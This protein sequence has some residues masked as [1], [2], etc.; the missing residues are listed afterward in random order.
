MVFSSFCLP[1]FAQRV[2]QPLPKSK[3]AFIVIAHRGSHLIKPEN[4]I[5]SIEEAILIGADYVEL[6]LRTTKDG[7]LVLLH[8]DEVDQVSNGKGP[9]KDLDF[10]EVQTLILKGKDGSLH[11]IAT[12]EEALKTCKDRINIYLDF[13]AAD[14]VQAYREIKRA[15]MEKAILVYVNNSDQYQSW[16]RNAPKIPLMSGLSEK[17]VTKENLLESLR[18]TPLEAIDNIPAKELLPIIRS[19]G[20]SIFLDVQKSSETPENWY[21]AMKKGI[22]GMQ[23]DHPKELIGYLE[24]HMIRNGLKEN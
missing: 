17:A 7:H 22:Q 11:H 4:T 3:H 5:A 6:D 16:R 13:K 18:K 9:I 15:G 20:I 24:K 21:A 2:L 8:N 14:V 12:F 1:I 23:T 19:S 10:K